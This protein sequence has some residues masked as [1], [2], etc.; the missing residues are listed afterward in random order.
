M[1]KE[2][3]F[4]LDLKGVDTSDNAAH[5]PKWARTLL[6]ESIKFAIRIV[7]LLLGISAV[8][9]RPGN[10]PLHPVLNLYSGSN[11]KLTDDI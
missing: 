4:S 2:F 1:L 6:G 8:A 9:L 3:K 11:N 5:Q 10:V 7:A